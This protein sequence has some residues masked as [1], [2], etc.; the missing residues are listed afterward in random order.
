MSADR[1]QQQPYDDQL[2]AQ[3]LSLKRTSAPGE[4]PGYETQR[5]LGSG[6]Y[7]EVWVGV[8]RTT[9]RQVAIKFFRH[10]T[11]VDWQLLS[12]EVEK[13]V[14]LSA[15]RYV[16]QLLDVGWSHDPPYY[17]MEY[18]ENGSLED[19]LAQQPALPVAEAVRLFRDVTVGLLHAHGKGVLHC[20]LKPANILLDEDHKPRLADFGQSRLSHEQTPALGTLFYMA[21]EQADLEA[22]PDA[23]WDVYALGA[24]L[25]C[26]V[27][28]GPPHRSEETVKQIDTA[29]DLPDRLAR[30]RQ[31][32]RTAPPLTAHRKV[33]GMD[34]ALAEILERCLAVD[35]DARF[36][37]VQAVLDAL[38][39]RRE[40]QQRLP[41]TVLGIVAPVMLLLIMAL[42]GWRGYHRAIVDSDA[43]II[44]RAQESN[45]FA[46]QYVAT[47]VSSE[48]ER[49][50]RAVERVA[51]DPE[52]QNLVIETV[53]HPELAPLVNRLSDP[54]AMQ[55]MASD[56]ERF[57]HHPAR[58]KLQRRVE[59]LMA[60][61]RKPRAA[62]WFVT[63]ADGLQIASVFDGE[64]I[65]GTIGRNFAWRTY[66]HGGES[67]LPRDARPPRVAHIRRTSL[68]APYQSTGT[69]AW[70]VAVST[71]VFKDG[72]F[73]GVVAMSIE[74]GNIIDFQG[75]AEHAQFAVL[76]DDRPGDQQGT[77]L[78][79]PLLHKM[80]EEYGQVPERFNKYRVDI[81]PEFDNP[82]YRYHDPLA[83]DREGA[84]YEG[85]WI[86]AAAPVKLPIARGDTEG[87]TGASG[88]TVLVQ[89]DWS[90]AAAPAHQLAR[91]LAREG[92]WAL[93]IVMVV[94]FSLW[95]FVVRNLGEWRESPVKPPRKKTPRRPLAGQPTMG[96]PT[97]TKR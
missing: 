63:S 39:A 58:G 7:G 76:V 72:R 33:R 84:A 51:D 96:M 1:T 4:V 40:R 47:N 53:E 44:S 93:G 21:P 8:D 12:R 95:F 37:N 17:V 62:S 32:I 14:F 22:V 30:Y 45:Q 11:G 31:S 49:Y 59:E 90:A 41:L 6:A 28:G 88:L 83:Q 97:E 60:D 50:Y 86:V 35:P 16:V 9:G 73:L 20:D 94:I 48:I 2:R 71:P 78:Q 42:F 46:A 67:D 27:T 55:G 57:I 65:G 5:L 43:A 82:K 52:F 68:S 92:L 15:D 56:R 70:K 38:E 69:K 19:Y 25:Y 80:R 54:A 18:V 75:N 36:P 10:R 64:T 24:L 79:H 34:R 89:E 81:T 61:E 13:L 74:L 23:R 85:D 29:V 91:R 3:Q 77:I 26:M 66:F 87:T